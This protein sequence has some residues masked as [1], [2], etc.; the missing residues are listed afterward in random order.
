MFIQ[1][2]IPA[3][4]FWIQPIRQQ[5]SGYSHASTATRRRNSRSFNAGK[6]IRMKCLNVSIQYTQYQS[7]NRF[8]LVGLTFNSCFAVSEHVT[9]VLSSCSGLLYALRILRT[10]GMPAISLYDVFRATIVAKTSLLF[11]SVVWILFCSTFL[12][13][14]KRYRYCPDNFQTVSELF[15]DTD[16]QLFSRT[17]HIQ[18]HVPKSL[19]PPLYSQFWT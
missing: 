10:H 18:T 16:Y 6:C 13:R 3:V 11:T 4:V 7:I 9:K 1:T 8:I 2:V 5:L 17:S 12:K 14:Y 19:L 15:S